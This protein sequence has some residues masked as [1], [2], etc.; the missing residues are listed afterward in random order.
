MAT[1][2]R[3]F[4]AVALS[5]LAALGATDLRAS[6]AYVE[7]GDLLKTT[8]LIVVATLTDA[9]EITASGVDYGRG[10]LKVRQVLYPSDLKIDTLLLRWRN[11]TD[12]VCPRVDPRPHEGAI[13]LWLLTR[14][15]DGSVR[16]DYP[17]RTISLGEQSHL[18]RLR[19]EI[20]P[21]S[22]DESYDTKV[23]AIEDLLRT[24]DLP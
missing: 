22:G 4:L 8:D 6:W 7:G 3:G 19:S 1:L 10:V 23:L 9:S 2:H 20:W 21:L 15:E 11:E 18:D 12:L 13:A 24:G 5:C 16:A 14:S 17:R